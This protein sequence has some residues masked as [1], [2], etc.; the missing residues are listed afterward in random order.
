M[1]E[2]IDILKLTPDQH[3]ALVCMFCAMLPKTDSR[4]KKRN[5]YW[6][7]LQRRFN[8][9]VS[10]YKFAKDTFDRYFPGNNRAGWSDERAL[11]RRG[12]EFQVVY[13]MFKDYDVELWRLDKG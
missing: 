4:Y 3:Q 5:S 6:E 9:K 7:V 12:K 2:K 13:D 11:E 1:T 10:T 8:K